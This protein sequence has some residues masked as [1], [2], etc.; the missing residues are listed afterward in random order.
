MLM[1]PT[2]RVGPAD[3]ERARPVVARLPFFESDTAI[4]A[5]LR[6]R[7]PAGGAA[8]YDR[9]HEHVRRVL[10]RLLGPGAHVGDLVQDV[11][12]SAIDSIDSL[13]RPES[14]RAWLASIAVFR[15]RAEIRSRARSRWFPLFA[16]D[17]LPEMDAEVASPEIDEAVKTTYTVLEKLGADERIAFALRFVDGMELV[18]VAEACEVSLATI[19]RRL[20][21]A[22]AK[23]VNI[24][25]TYPVLSE[26]LERGARWT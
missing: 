24:A 16:S 17:D 18:E 11:F 20:T 13:E 2:K 14:L 8:L 9:H 10:I 5:A 3:A 23:F 15:A 22:Q 12:V 26:W 25:R 1:A 4:V 6:A 7:Q 21:R 19:K